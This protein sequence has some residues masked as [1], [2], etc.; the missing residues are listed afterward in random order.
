MLPV[1]GEQSSFYHINRSCLNE[2]L[3]H[4]QD[5]HHYH[6]QYEYQFV[7]QWA[8]C[9][10][11][12]ED[13]LA[14]QIKWKLGALL[15]VIYYLVKQDSKTIFVIAPNKMYLALDFAHSYFHSC[16]QD[17]PYKLQTK[18]ILKYLGQATQMYAMIRSCIM[19]KKA[20]WPKKGQA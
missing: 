2:S 13:L 10:I 17:N 20:R 7:A 15:E 6:H 1:H 14:L 16:L 9:N 18:A 4:W 11:V 19:H 12:E 8:K 5:T 3:S